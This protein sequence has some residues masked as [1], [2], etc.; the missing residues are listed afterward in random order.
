MYY[1]SKTSIDVLRL[2]PKTKG[3]QSQLNTETVD[4]LKIHLSNI[5]FRAFRKI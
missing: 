5:Y 1:L 2:V 3:K 4:Y